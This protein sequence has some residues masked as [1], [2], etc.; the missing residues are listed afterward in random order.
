MFRKMMRRLPAPMTGPAPSDATIQEPVRTKTIGLPDISKI[1]A[2][3]EAPKTL[4]EMGG[5]PCARRRLHSMQSGENPS[6]RIVLLALLPMIIAFLFL[7]KRC[8]ARKP[9][10]N[11]EQADENIDD[12]LNMV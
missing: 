9:A 5:S 2:D 4:D 8:V 10:Q 12:A 7:F 1:R 6:L 3:A 11:N